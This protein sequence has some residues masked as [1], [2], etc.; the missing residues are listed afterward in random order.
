M[1]LTDFAFEVHD[2]AVKHG[3]WEEEHPF[4]EIVAL[5][6]SELSEALEEYR[7]GRPEFYQLCTSSDGSPCLRNGCGDWSDGVCELNSLDSDPKGVAVELADA[8][9]RIFDWFGKEHLDTAELI[10]EAHERRENMHDIPVPVKDATFAGLIGRWHAMVSAAYMRWYTASGTHSAALRLAAVV[11][12]LTAWIDRNGGD[13]MELLQ[14]KHQ[15][16][17]NRTYRHGGKKI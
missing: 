6:H 8:V 3:W 1:T 10:G 11:G 14:M 2:N 17:K 16:N 5:I 4:D 15:Y 12:E 9:L 7:L 13:S